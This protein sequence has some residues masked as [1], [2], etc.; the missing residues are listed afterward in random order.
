LN[1]VWKHYFCF[2]TMP[3]GAAHLPMINELKGHQIC[4][5]VC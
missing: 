1:S 5:M 3:P 4:T 2:I